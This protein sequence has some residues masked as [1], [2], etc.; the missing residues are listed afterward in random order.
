[1]NELFPAAPQW[2]EDKGKQKEIKLIMWE[3]AIDSPKKVAVSNKLAVN[4]KLIISSDVEMKGIKGEQQDYEGK[5]LWL[6]QNNGSD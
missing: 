2:K 1:M 5:G 6:P 3:T 4:I